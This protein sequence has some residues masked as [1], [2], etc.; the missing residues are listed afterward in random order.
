MRRGI[1]AAVGDAKLGSLF[2]F[3]GHLPP[4]YSLSRNTQ[5]IQKGVQ[6]ISP[7]SPEALYCPQHG[8]L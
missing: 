4:K 7:L 5:G 2:P 8:E 1:S 3:G 6:K